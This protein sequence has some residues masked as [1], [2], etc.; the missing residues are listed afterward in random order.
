VDQRAEGKRPDAWM[1]DLEEV[2]AEERVRVDV[3]EME[4]DLPR[5][6]GELDRGG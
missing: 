5:G 3:I 6:E 4:P 2:Q 1:V